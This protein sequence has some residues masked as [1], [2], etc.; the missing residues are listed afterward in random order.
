MLFR[1]NDDRERFA[2][3]DGCEREGDPLVVTN[4]VGRGIAVGVGGARHGLIEIGED[5]VTQLVADSTGRGRVGK[6]GWSRVD[7][8]ALRGSEDEYVPDVIRRVARTAEFR[9][10]TASPKQALA[11]Y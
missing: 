1:S 10:P 9:Q 3:V 2:F 4:D 6:V 7:R 8:T 11:E 5:V